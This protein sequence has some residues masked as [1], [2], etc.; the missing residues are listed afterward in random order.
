MAFK[1]KFFP[2]KEELKTHK[3]LRFLHAHMHH[4][5]LW[6][7]GQSELS[8]A[9]VI[10]VF[11]AM[12][13]MPFQMIPAAILALVLR[14]N[15]IVSVGLVWLSNPVTMLPMLYGAYVFGCWLYGVVPVFHEESLAWHEMFTHMH[16]I[17]VPLITGCVIIGLAGGSLL[18]S[19]IWLVFYFMR[20][21]KKDRLPLE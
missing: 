12:M 5:F 14:A 21:C 8:R 17:F 6:H 1:R 15:I 19:I 10:G 13:P 4:D 11:M 9:A 16:Q 20:K 3:W 2:T 18:G 7:F